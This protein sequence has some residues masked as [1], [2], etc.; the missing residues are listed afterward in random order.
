MLRTRALI[1]IFALTAVASLSG[2][3]GNMSLICAATMLWGYLDWVGQGRPR[4]VL[5]G[6][7]R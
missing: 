4:F 1:L 7:T 5:R 3:S 2:L 6:P